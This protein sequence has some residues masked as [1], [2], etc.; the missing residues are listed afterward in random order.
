M[1]EQDY[2]IEGRVVR[3]RQHR[4]ESPL[5]TP[6]FFNCGWQRFCELLVDVMGA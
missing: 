4:R 1:A 6:P 3:S 2:H 5:Q